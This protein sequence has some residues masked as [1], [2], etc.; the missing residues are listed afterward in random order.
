MVEIFDTNN[1]KR[2]KKNQQLDRYKRRVNSVDNIF[3]TPG[4]QLEVNHLKWLFPSRDSSIK[5]NVVLLPGQ[6]QPT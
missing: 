2:E 6:W 1:A 4:K 3:A 5:M